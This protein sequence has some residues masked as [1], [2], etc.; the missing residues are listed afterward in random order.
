MVRPFLSMTDDEWHHLL[1]TNLHGYYY[2][3]RAAALRMVPEGN[4]RI[5]NITSVTAIQPITGC[6]AYVTAK[7]GVIGLTKTLAVELG[8]SGVTVNAIAPGAVHSR[9]NADV[10]TPAVQKVYEDRIPRGRIGQ[11]ADIAAAAVFLA[12][13]EASYVT[14]QQIAVDGGLILNGNVGFDEN[15]DSQ[16]GAAT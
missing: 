12:S 11:P 8:H 13:D 15:P 1:A 4:G 9:L 10:Y 6:T 2:G 16:G 3:C 14:G 5:I 7:G